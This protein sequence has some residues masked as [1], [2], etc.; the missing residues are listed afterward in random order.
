M[1]YVT[2]ED[3]VKAIRSND[4]VFIQGGAASPQQLI[5][6]IVHYLVTEHGVA[7][8]YGKT[9]RERARALIGIAAPEHREALERAAHER[10]K[11]DF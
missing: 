11:M 7:Y 10:F 3:A 2:A 6:A 5:N 9:L 1:K 4:R 8:L